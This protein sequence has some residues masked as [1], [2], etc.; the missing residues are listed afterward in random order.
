MGFSS[1]AY[2]FGHPI[3]FGQ[4]ALLSSLKQ[5]AE[6]DSALF[7]Q[8]FKQEFYKLVLGTLSLPIGIPGTNYRRGFQVARLLVLFLKKKK[9]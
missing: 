5:I 3:L 2:F 9:K 8:E 7:S 1:N 6:I 4:M